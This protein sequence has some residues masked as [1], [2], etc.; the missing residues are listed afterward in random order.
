MYLT[1]SNLSRGLYD[2]YTNLIKTFINQIELAK[3]FNLNIS[4]IGKY[5]K[6]G[7]LI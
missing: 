7:K 6:S 3:Y 4:T 1:K 2:L 5:L